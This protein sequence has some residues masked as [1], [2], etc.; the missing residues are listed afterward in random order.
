LIYDLI[1]FYEFFIYGFLI[2][3]LAVL[4]MFL[5]GL[6]DAEF[7]NFLSDV[8]LL[9]V[10]VDGRPLDKLERWIFLKRFNYFNI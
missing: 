5:N 10:D 6:F 9:I 1:D 4:L 8:L 3:D 7:Y 2:D